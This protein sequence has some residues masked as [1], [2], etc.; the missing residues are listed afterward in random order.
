[1]PTSGWRLVTDL[2]SRH[3]GTMNKHRR[4]VSV[5]VT[6]AL[7]TGLLCNSAAASDADPYADA[8]SPDT[9]AALTDPGN[10]LGAPDGQFTTV[11]GHL[12]AWIVLDLGAGEE[13]IGNLDVYYRELD[14]LVDQTDVEFLQANG[15]RVAYASLIMFSGSRVATLSNTSTTPYRYVRIRAGS[16][17]RYGLDAIKVAALA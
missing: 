16:V 12:G 7:A 15:K 1:V 11:T 8:V 2:H 6:I 9:T 10:V 4:I 5:L 3:V 14:L 13:G 17:Q